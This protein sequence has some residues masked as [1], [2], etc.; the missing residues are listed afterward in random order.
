VHYFKYKYGRKLD[1]LKEEKWSSK[2]H[3]DGAR[4][5]HLYYKSTCLEYISHMQN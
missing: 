2:R 3:G 4:D 1:N 5:L